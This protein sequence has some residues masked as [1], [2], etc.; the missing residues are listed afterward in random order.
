MDSASYCD[1][2]FDT[3]HPPWRSILEGD[4]LLLI[5]TDPVRY[6]GVI[7]ECFASDWLEAELTTEGSRDKNVRLFKRNVRSVGS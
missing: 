5:L 3:T 4:L 6:L 1:S 7:A 2:P